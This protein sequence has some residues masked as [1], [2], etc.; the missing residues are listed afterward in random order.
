[1]S[2]IFAL[3]TPPGKSGVA[4][5]RISGPNTKEVLTALGCAVIPE[6]RYAK[7]CKILHP[8]TKDVIDEGI[9][10]WFP[11]PASF[12]G[13]DVAELQVHGSRAVIH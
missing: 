7:L 4:V 6:P 8:I 1:M 12:T 3:A 2:T 11:A 9:I 13:E 5:I 10:L